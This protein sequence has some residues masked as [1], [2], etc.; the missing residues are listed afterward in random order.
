MEEIVLQSSSVSSSE[1]EP[2]VRDRVQR[3]LEMGN[4]VDTILYD[5]KGIPWFAVPCPLKANETNA[6]SDT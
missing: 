3:A 5:E 1:L 2:S 4:F 6:G